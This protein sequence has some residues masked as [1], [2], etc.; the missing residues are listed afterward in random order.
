MTSKCP[1]GV[2]FLRVHRIPPWPSHSVRMAPTSARTVSTLLPHG[3]TA[4]PSGAPFL[5]EDGPINVSI[6]IFTIVGILCFIAVPVFILRRHPKSPPLPPIQPLA[7][8]RERESEYLPQPYLPH[9]SMEFDK[10]NHGHGNVKVSLEPFCTP[11]FRSIDSSGT[12]S[13]TC[14][15]ASD[16]PTQLSCPSSVESQSDEHTSTQLYT[17]TACLARS[18]SLS[19]SRPMRNIFRKPSMISARTASTHMRSASIIRGAPHRSHNN[20]DLVLP[21][22][23]APQLQNYMIENSSVIRSCGRSRERRSD[24]WMDALIIRTTSWPSFT[25]PSLSVGDGH[26]KRLCRFDSL[27]QDRLTWSH[28]Y[29]DPGEGVLHV[30]PQNPNLPTRGVPQPLASDHPESYLRSPVTDKVLS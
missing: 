14:Y 6:I 5:L 30:V 24:Q 4:S 15:P 29:R 2:P 18:S 27:C 11:S 7:H 20:V 19:R 23:L 13:C 21:A 16:P 9:K 26:F 10:V 25:D 8:Y 28:L 17:S 1:V 22:P 3:G 12:P